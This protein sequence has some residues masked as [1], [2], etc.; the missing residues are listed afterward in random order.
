MSKNKKVFSNRV[1][2]GLL[3]VLLGL[4]VFFGQGFSPRVNVRAAPTPAPSGIITIDANIKY[5]VIQGFGS[6][7]RV[8][9][10]PHM[11]NNNA[12]ARTGRAATTLTQSQQDDVYRML[13]TELGLT[14]V[15]PVFEAGWL[16]EVNDNHD[17]YVTDPN[18]FN[19]DWKRNDAHVD[20]VNR[21]IPFGLQTYIPKPNGW[22]PWMNNHPDPAEIAEWTLARL[23]RWKQLGREPQFYSLINEPSHINDAWTGALLRDVIKNLGPRM[24]AKGIKTMLIVPDELNPTRGFQQ[25]SIILADPV[26]R[27]YVGA[28]STHLYQDSNSNMSKLKLL[29][30]QYD[31]PIWMTEYSILEL[32]QDGKGIE[33]FEWAL[34]MHDLLATYNVSAIDYMWGFFGDW[35][36][37]DQ[38][39][40]ALKTNGSK[41]EGAER[42]KEFYLTGQYS[43]Y[44]RPGS[45]RIGSSSDDSGIKVTA[46]TN[47]NNLTIVVLNSTTV[48]KNPLFTFLGLNEVSSLQ[49][50]RTSE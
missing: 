33:A 26:A 11:F 25:M 46:Y 42:T 34:L 16:E 21:A 7:E 6:S 41:Y 47:G 1:I 45:R 3:V 14:R 36:G 18:S 5:Q 35:V 49:S 50:V 15:L 2:A 4:A 23:G 32:R 30:E 8:F 40:V 43:K 48:S 29:S 31:L 44:V 12:D 27:Q 10:D 9:D 13:Y 17:P 22:E 37:T 19:F 38:Q 20:Y 28:I 39:L 24:R